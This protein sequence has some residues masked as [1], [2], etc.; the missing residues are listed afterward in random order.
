MNSK[1]SIWLLG[2]P[3]GHSMSPAF[4]NAGL[5]ALGL[6]LV[7]AARRTSPGELV[8]LVDAIRQGQAVGANVTLPHKGAMGVL[9]DRISPSARRAG[10]INT[11]V[12]V[13]GEVEGHN[14]DVPG[15]LRA[16]R[17]RDLASGQRA[18]VLG[19]GGAAR[20]AVVAL[21]QAGFEFITIISRDVGRAEILRGE[22]APG[23][24]AQ[25]SVVEA[26]RAAE[27]VAG[28]PWLGAEVM[29]HATSL[30]VGEVEGD[31]AFV[32]AEAVWRALPW[33]DLGKLRGVHDM[34]YGRSETPF[35]SA[36]RAAGV[37]GGDGLSMLLYQGL[38][39]FLMWTGRKPPEAVMR[40]ALEEAAG[41]PLA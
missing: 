8:E 39:S 25:L 22:L 41:R 35:L 3:V 14:T 24:C 16:L 5:T 37:K 36:A 17:E 29:V 28:A 32:E 33:H 15:L 6:P 19:A 20:A 12:K 34:C 2:D 23:C 1:L 4:Q 10:A 40:R 27:P 11:L 7:Y 13:A 30:G 9:V 18:V 38:E 26:A 31:P 21:D